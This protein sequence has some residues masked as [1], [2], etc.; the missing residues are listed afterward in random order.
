MEVYVKPRSRGLK[1]AADG[2]EIVV[3]CACAHFYDFCI[4]NLHF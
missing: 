3:F 4:R 1:I 2:D